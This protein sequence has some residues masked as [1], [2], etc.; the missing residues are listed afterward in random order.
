MMKDR[1]VILEIKKAG[2][3][4]EGIGFYQRKPVFVDGCFPGE[5]VSCILFDEGRHMRG[6]LKK[7]IRRSKHR[8]EPVC[9]LQRICGSCTLMA[10]D[11]PEQLRIKKQ[12]LEGAL[13]KYMR[14]PIDVEEIVPSAKTIH[15]RN[16][17]SLPLIEHNGVIVNALYRQGSNHPV[18]MDDCPIH[19]EGV[20]DIRKQ[21]LEVLNRHG[22][23]VYVHRERKGLRQLMVRGMNGRYQAVIVSGNDT[24]SEELISDLKKIDGLCSLFQGINTRKDP[25]R[26]IP[27][28]LK[29]IFGKERIDITVN[30]RRLK[31]SP[32][33][34]FQ[35]NHGQAERIY[36]DAAKLLPAG[37]ERVVEAYCGIG[38]I[39]L[40]LADKVKELIGIEIV[41][42]AIRD[43][44]ENA[45]ENGY[46]D[47]RF[48][49]DDAAKGLRTIL[50]EGRVDALIVDPP[51]TGLDDSLLETLLKSRIKTIIYISCNPSTLAKDLSVLS[52]R[53]EIE[54]IRGY[55]MFPNT[56]L[57][58]TVVKLSRQ[59]LD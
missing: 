2:I 39:S 12:L 24:L 29:R 13:L 54:S 43:A 59:K 16:K 49:C 6:R 5:K 35:L 57:V 53:Y 34:F 10:V 9:P 37:C 15:Y 42:E 41:E 48:I 3:N 50:K 19:E 7:I 8:I 44:R 18:L 47:L 25:V 36:E 4:G 17:C 23:R 58:E 40:C 27:D 11:H 21:I 26:M 28:R 1:E 32:Q 51:R 55:D 20:E 14:R 45:K 56:P 46:D 31:L 22:C 33:A 38:A 30:G 52:G